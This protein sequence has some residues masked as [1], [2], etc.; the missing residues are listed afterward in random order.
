MPPEV[1]EVWGDR[2]GV[3][4]VGESHRCRLVLHYVEAVGM[5]HM[6]ERGE[7]SD[8]YRLDHRVNWPRVRALGLGSSCGHT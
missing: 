4:L 3:K 6:P 8:G 5:G 1:V 7:V 2:P